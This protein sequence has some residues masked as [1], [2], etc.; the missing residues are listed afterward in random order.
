ML[1]FKYKKYAVFL[2]AF[3]NCFLIHAHVPSV[4]AEK[5]KKF[6]ADMID[7]TRAIARK[8][9]DEQPLALGHLFMKHCDIDFF[10]KSIR[11][12]RTMSESQK[13]RFKNICKARIMHQ[14][15]SAEKLEKFLDY[16][17]DSTKWRSSKGQNDDTNVTM[18][19]EKD[20]QQIP[21]EMMV[22]QKNGRIMITDVKIEGIS[23]Y[24]AN[25]DEMRSIFSSDTIESSLK[26]L[27]SVF[28]KELDELKK[29]S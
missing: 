16:K 9:E 2:L 21:V 14:Y 23:M 20:D 5:A 19:F 3:L 12:Y 15:G 10:A 4:P 7:Q 22:H 13:Q 18:M 6:V 8:S 25:R 1:L 11:V 17:T 27:E 24:I 26:K 29:I 28:K